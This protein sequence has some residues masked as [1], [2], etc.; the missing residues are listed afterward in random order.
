MRELYFY[1]KGVILR[2]ILKYL[3]SDGIRGCLTFGVQLF[4]A[5]R[6]SQFFQRCSREL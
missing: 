2:P 3:F 4:K 1:F 5:A 6:V